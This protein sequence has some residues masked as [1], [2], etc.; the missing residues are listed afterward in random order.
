MTAAPGIT[1]SPERAAPLNVGWQQRPCVIPGIEAL[2][3]TTGRNHGL[4]SA[5]V[6]KGRAESGESRQHRRR[7]EARRR[8]VASARLIFLSCPDGFIADDRLVPA[9]DEFR[10]VGEREDVSPAVE[11]I[12]AGRVPGHIIPGR[13][14]V[15][16]F[17]QAKGHWNDCGHVR[18]QLRQHLGTMDV[19]GLARVPWLVG[20][21][22]DRIAVPGRNLTDSGQVAGEV[23]RNI[24]RS[25]QRNDFD[26]KLVPVGGL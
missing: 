6:M 11:A 24:A 13:S 2:E 19:S 10:A 4:Q 3:L 22:D 20:N 16:S 17:H 21:F 25:S 18:T 8:I 14:S 1:G 5:F 15:Q 12:V 9:A 7:A 26:M 23:H